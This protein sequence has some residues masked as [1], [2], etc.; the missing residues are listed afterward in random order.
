MNSNQTNAQL[1]L[2]VIMTIIF[3]IMGIVSLYYAISAIRQSKRNDET[4]I[5][6]L[7][8]SYKWALLTGI[9]TIIAS[10][11]MVILLVCLYM[12]K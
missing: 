6:T 9:T 2:S 8:K 5:V 4:Y 3:P 1:L 12:F 7:D 11:G 10:V